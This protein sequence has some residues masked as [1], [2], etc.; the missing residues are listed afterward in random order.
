MSRIGS[1]D[2]FRFLAIVAV[3]A[4]HT[5][6]FRTHCGIEND[7]YRCIDV[8]IN[9]LARFAVPFFFVISGYF[10]GAKVRKGGAPLATAWGMAS[11]VLVL[12]LAWS[13]LYLLP[14]N[15]AAFLCHGVPGPI[16]AARR[17]ITDLVQNPLALIM[18]GTKVHLWF[19]V[20]LLFSLGISAVFVHR[21]RIKSLAVVSIFLYAIGVLAKAY[22]DTPIGIDVEFNTRN[23]PFFGTLFFV[24]GYVMSGFV[25]S[26]KWLKCG[27]SVFC[28]GC[29][30]HFSEIY[31]LWRTF[32]TSPTQDFVLGTYFMGVGV[33]MAS[34]SN[35]P[36][37]QNRLFCAIGQMTL[38]I[39]AVHFIFVDLF[40]AVDRNVYSPSWEVGYVM[41]VFL[42]SVLSSVALSRSRITRRLVMHPG[43][44]SGTRAVHP[45]SP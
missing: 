21:K 26:T 17:N 19:L 4:I 34:L 43:V 10:W 23:G 2:L 42:L 7:L 9:Q 41:L 3:I 6:P 12:F 30:V 14:Y 8:V 27:L 39:Y 1:L 5:T 28:L 20:S 40:E 11:R 22:A 24:S 37:L 45:G 32:G 35:H 38:G 33:A 29:A 13:L 36:A 25:P 31:L 44:L 18:Q 16:E 15:F